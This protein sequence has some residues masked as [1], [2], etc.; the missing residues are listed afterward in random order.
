[1]KTQF[2]NLKFI[3][4]GMFFSTLMLA[5]TGDVGPTLVISSTINYN[6]N[7]YAASKTNSFQIPSEYKMYQVNS[8]NT[9]NASTGEFKYLNE[10]VNQAL[11]WNFQR[12]IILEG[13]Y[14]VNN[15][16][17]IDN[18]NGSTHIN[19]TGN[20]T[21]EGEGFG[22]KINP[23]GGYTGNIFEVRS[24]Y[25]TIKNLA[26]H[27]EGSGT[28]IYVAQD[29][30]VTA[31]DPNG[32]S[33]EIDNY[34][35]TFENLYIGHKALYGSTTQT[36][37]AAR[38]IVLDG[39][40]KDV[41]YNKFSNIV[42][43]GLHTGITFRKGAVSGARI[44]DNVFTNV[45][46]ARVVRGIFFDST[47]LQESTQ[48]GQLIY[49]DVS[50]NIFSNFSLQTASVTEYYV[51]NI[52]GRNN[53][54]SN[55]KSADWGTYNSDIA[56]R[57]VFSISSKAQHTTIQNSEV[58]RGYVEQIK[59]GIVDPTNTDANPTLTP[60][61][62]LQL[63]NN[64]GGNSDVTYRLGNDTSDNASAI[65]KVEVLGEFVS[66]HDGKNQ[67]Y[68][69]NG[70]TI[71]GN[72]NPNLLTQINT[73]DPN[74]D[75]KLIVNGKV[76]VRNEV[77][78]KEAGLT[79]PDYVF[80]NDYKLMPLQ[81]VAQHIQ[82]KGHLPNMPSA[83]EVEKDGIA[84]GGIIKRQQEKIEELTLYLIEKHRITYNI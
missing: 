20:I 17:I 35:N 43:K 83:T 3:L 57:A 74:T 77:Y 1:M 30:T 51:H 71:I 23:A 38:G 50:D 12:I 24:H 7:N 53:T 29:A 33:R 28:G 41:G 19:A 34:H 21:I 46:F 76:R 25:N 54:F 49:D 5:Q 40:Y 52:Y 79:W 32:V 69:K 13:E 84:V 62:Y 61:K 60:S 2:Y 6:T 63:I 48:S 26:I 16:I 31:N 59:D 22:T 78:V 47:N 67:I 10:A 11:T 45:N 66:S 58:G 72:I 18:T 4:L 37:V 14:F 73:Q 80:A 27:I 56:H 44:H 81:Q 15:A 42:I 55:F 70:R 8:A 9:T 64:Y 65:S 36:N 75:Y 82:E 39:Q 68:A